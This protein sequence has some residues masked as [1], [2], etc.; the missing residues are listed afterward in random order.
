MA[1]YKERIFKKL[2]VFLFINLEN[3]IMY[4]IAHKIATAEIFYH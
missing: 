3:N 1:K 2:T 4:H